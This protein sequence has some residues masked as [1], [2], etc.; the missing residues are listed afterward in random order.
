MFEVNNRKNVDQRGTANP[1]PLSYF[2]SHP[3]ECVHLFRQGD[4]IVSFPDGLSNDQV[5]DWV[6]TLPGISPEWICGRS[7][8]ESH[9]LRY[10]YVVGAMA[11]AITSTQMVI[12]CANDGILCFFGSAGLDEKTIATSIAKIG[13]HVS[14]SASWGANLIHAP[15]EPALE[16][17]TAKL[18]VDQGVRFVSASAYLKLSEAVVFAAFSG[19]RQDAQGGIVRARSVFAK[20][21]RP[22]TA[23]AFMQAPSAKLLTRL[24]DA[25]HLNEEECRLAARCSVATDI[26][27]ESDSGGHT[28]NQALGALFPRISELREQLKADVRL[29]AAGG[30]GSPRSLA[31][32][33]ALGADFLLTGTVNQTTIE[34]GL[35]SYGKTLLAKADIGDV[36]MAPAADMFEMGVK[37]QVLKRG[38]MFGVRAQR[39]W[40]AYQNY[41]DFE[42]MPDEVKQ[43]L[44][45]DILG[46]SVDDIWEACQRFFAERDPLQ[47]EKA[48][49]SSRHKMALVFRWYLGKSSR[50]ANAGKLE[51]K[52]DFQIWCGPA[53][54]AF[55]S[56]IKGS[57]LEDPDQRRVVQL[58]KNLM[59]GATMITRANQLRQF[60]L[61]PPPKDWDYRPRK[62]DECS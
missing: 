17:A 31:A 10:P 25:G 32:A 56:W 50:W 58:A 60:G 8:V 61:N 14:E 15:H 18:F 53:I 30:L 27:V 26:I 36:M 40:E 28:D 48:Q 38:T 6:G 33:I 46:E 19:I 29:G 23:A 47:L 41:R 35:S 16:F 39:L 52:L 34:S 54:A 5:G 57:F 51:R 21:S 20:I 44:E 59:E 24:M 12:A 9:N 11:N 37:L 22:E 13:H 4:Q 43:K 45:D 1:L 49:A 55:N 62:L 2:I 42:A 7:F 3:R